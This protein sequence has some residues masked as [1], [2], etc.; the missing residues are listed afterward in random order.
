MYPCQCGGFVWL[1]DCLWCLGGRWCVWPGYVTY[2]SCPST[3][4]ADS[5]L[6]QLAHLFQLL[7]SHSMVHLLHCPLCLIS[8]LFGHHCH[9][10]GIPNHLWCL[11]VQS[12]LPN[13]PP[14]PLSQHCGL[15]LT[16][17]AFLLVLVH[18][19]SCLACLP[20]FCQPKATSVPLNGSCSPTVD[21]SI[22]HTPLGKGPGYG[23]SESM[24]FRKSGKQHL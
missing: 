4:H 1:V 11:L 14:G 18:T 12:C 2:I 19:Q 16:P 9:H 5:S 3:A 24:E 10:F 13:W 15:I 20:T 6:P 23:F 21:S 8:H 7:S 17:H 22:T